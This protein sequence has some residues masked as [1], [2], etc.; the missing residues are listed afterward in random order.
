MASRP[1][2]LLVK[3]L[4][5]TFTVIAVLL[6]VVFAVV[7]LMVRTQVRDA[8]AANLESSQRMFAALETRRQRELVAEAGT[9]A[10]NPTL[11]A[12]LDIYQSETRSGNG[13]ARADLIETIDRELEKVAARIDNDAIVLTD[14]RQLTIAAAGRLADRWPHGRQVN[15]TGVQG[16]AFDGVVHLGGSV[17]RLVAVPLQLDDGSTIGTLYLASS[18]DPAYVDALARLSG[19]R[20]AILSDSLVVASTLPAAAAHELESALG[21][22]KPLDGTATLDGQLFAFR[23]LVS[24]GDTMVYA[25][26]SIDES[27]RTAQ[28]QAIQSLAGIAAI[29]LAV[30]LGGSLWLA[31][32]LA[33]PIDRLSTSLAAMA[34]S[35]RMGERI[36]LPGSSR[37]VDALTDTFNALMA[38][39]AAAEADT[40][41]AYTGAIR[42]LATALDARDPYTAGHSERVAV[43]SVAIGRAL[44]LGADDI[45]VLRLGALL[46]DIGKIGVPDDVLRKPGA[47]TDAEFALIKQHPVLGARIL[48]SVPFLARHLS[49]VELH[50]ERPDGRGYPLGLRGDDIPLAARIVHVADAYDAMTSARA[51]RAA[52]PSGDALRELWRCAGTEFHAEIVGALATALPGVVSETGHVVLA[53]A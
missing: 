44:K 21:V 8:V 17:F 42:A 11:K 2:R 3:T 27:S 39:V 28:R 29:A 35:H 47:L 41:A 31:R 33:D 22:S 53:P 1:P 43:L 19:T 20:I 34:R 38:S 18:L 15:L 5:M 45:E 23:R 46:H 40:E 24:V 12:A 49:I 26:G 16:N 32:L 6:I 25:L 36:P 48:K 51:Y 37:E 10:E 30:A 14:M 9:L 7:W 50:H 52:R 4:A 13:G